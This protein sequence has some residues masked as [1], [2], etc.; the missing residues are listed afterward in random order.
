MTIAEDH[1]RASLHWRPTRYPEVVEYDMG[2]GFDGPKKRSPGGTVNTAVQELHYWNRVGLTT[3]TP[4]PTAMLAVKR[5]LE[6]TP[7]GVAVAIS[8]G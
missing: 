4:A 1:L 5:A 6:R 2:T 3:G 8:G 7:D